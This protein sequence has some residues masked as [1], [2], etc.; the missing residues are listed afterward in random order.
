MASTSK[1]RS[2]NPES[3]KDTFSMLNTNTKIR[4][5]RKQIADKRKST[6]Q[7]KSFQMAKVKIQSIR[8]RWLMNVSPSDHEIFITSAFMLLMIKREI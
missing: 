4:N 2:F 1:E 6:R 3:W 7:D 5:N 8:D